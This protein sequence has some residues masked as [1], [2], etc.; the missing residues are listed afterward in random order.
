MR[1]MHARP[2]RALATVD[3]AAIERNLRSIRA[4]LDGAAGLCAVVKADAYGHGAQAVARVALRVGAELLAVATAA[5]ATR[6][7]A[8]GV[9]ARVLVLGALTAEDLAQAI[10]AHA[11]VVAWRESFVRR[12]AGSGARVHVKLDSGMGRLGACDVPEATRVVELVRVDRSLALMGVMTHLATADEHGSPFMA[13]QLARF[14]R[15]A[16]PLKAAQ[17]ALTMHAA[18]SAATLAHPASHLDMVRVGLAQYGLD[19][20]QRDPGRWGLT[21]ALSL[22]SYV[23][24]VKPCRPGE[25]V[26]YGRAFLAQHPTRVATVPIGYA[27]GVRRALGGRGRVAIGD[28]LHPIVGRVSMDMLAVE[29]GV[30]DV[31]PG[32]TVE[33]I[34]SRL[35]AEAMA[36]DLDTINYE[37]TCGLS[38]RVTRRYVNDS[39]RS[40]SG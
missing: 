18:N 11:E 13:E 33:L 23:A 40:E 2:E 7:R 35:P 3:L 15:W 39:D 8:A 9:A 1:L 21:P 22:T 27:D 30:H 31:A 16:R 37:I 29:V 20:F 24:D 6:L 38:S 34:G 14:T 19:P 17:P 25:S 4:R 28:A 12:L 26:G 10:A 36:A 32:D 5:E